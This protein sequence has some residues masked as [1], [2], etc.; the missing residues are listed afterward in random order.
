[1]T[2]M[3]CC[4]ESYIV[5]IYRRD[6]ENPLHVVG[7]VETVGTAGTNVFN[8]PEELWKIL[9][10]NGKR[11]K[12]KRRRNTADEHEGRKTVHI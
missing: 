2:T 7:L 8:D 11:E 12:R 6:E 4:R 1:M 9:S 3:R 5:R 10:K